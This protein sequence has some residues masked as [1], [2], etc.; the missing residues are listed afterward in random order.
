MTDQ[1]GKIFKPYL[2]F[3]WQS[4]AVFAV[5]LIIWSAMRGSLEMGEF[6]MIFKDSLVLLL[7]LFIS[8]SL[9]SLVIHL[10]F[11]QTILI[12]DDK[13]IFTTR[14]GEKKINLSDIEYIKLGRERLF[15]F[16][17]KLRVIKIKVNGRRFHITIRPSAYEEDQELSDL[18]LK[19]K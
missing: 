17:E 9:V 14:F 11:N 3:Y 8:F 1:N 18:L 19:L 2:A 15:H 12:K 10:I 13:I 6:Y 7:L 16:R 4:I 5:I